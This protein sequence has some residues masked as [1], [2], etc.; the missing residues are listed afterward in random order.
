[1]V[2]RVRVQSEPNNHHT[3]KVNLHPCVGTFTYFGFFTVEKGLSSDPSGILGQQ[4]LACWP[5]DSALNSGRV[6]KRDPC[7]IHKSLNGDC[8]CV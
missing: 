5:C 1:M 6:L 2:G 3:N 8:P 7:P 4:H